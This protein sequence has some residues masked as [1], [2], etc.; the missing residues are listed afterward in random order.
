M[1]SYE[2]MKNNSDDDDDDHNSTQKAGLRVAVARGEKLA[3][4]TNSKAKA[5]A[6]DSS[7]SRE[8]GELSSSDDDDDDFHATASTSHLAGCDTA[9]ADQPDSA[10]ASSVDKVIQDA[11]RE[12]HDPAIKSASMVGLSSRASQRS[13]HLKSSEKNRG[14]FVPFVIS[15]SDDDSG[16]DS[17]D[18]RRNTL[19]TKDQTQGVDRSSRPPVSSLQRSPKL[20]QN[21]NKKARLVNRE[22]FPSRPFV[23][24]ATSWNCRQIPSSRNFSTVQKGVA[25]DHG[26]LQKSIVHVNTNKRQLQDLRQLIAIR[27]SQLKLKSTQQTK[28]SVGG[29]GSDGKFKNPGN[30]GNR[31]RKDSGFDLRG[32]LNKA[33]KKRLKTGKPQCS[34][35]D[36]DNNLHSLQPILTSGKSR[37]DNSGKE[38][39]DDH[40]HRSKKLSLGTSLSGVQKQSEARDSL[41]LENPLNTAIAGNCTVANN[42]QCARNPKQ[43]D[44]VI[45]LKQSGQIGKRATGDFPNRSLD[46]EEYARHDVQVSIQ[47]NVTSGTNLTER[48]DSDQAKSSDQVSKLKS[49]DKVQASSLHLADGNLQKASLSNPSLLNGLDKLNMMGNNMDL[50]SLLEYEELQDKEIEDAQEHRRRC[51]IEERNALM[52]YRKAQRALIEANARCSQLY[53]KR[54]LYSAQLRSLMM[55]NPNLVVSLRQHDQVE[56][57]LDSFNY[58]SDVNEHQIPAS[59]HQVH[60]G[61][62][63]NGIRGNN[64]N[65]PPAND[66]Y[67]NPSNMHV[68]GQNLVSDPCSKREG[69]P[70]EGHKQ[71]VSNGVCSPSGDLSQS[72]YQEG[73]IF[74]FNH[75]SAQENIESERT[76]EFNKDREKDIYEESERQPPFDS[77]QDCFLLEASL[78]SQLFEKLK[79]KKLPKKG[80]TQS[81]EDL[82][83]RNDENDDSRQMMETDTADV[84]LSEAENGKH[85]DYEDYSKEER[86]PELPVQINNQFDILH[87]EHASSS[88]DVC[89][90]SCISL[91]SQ[92]FK[93]SGTFLLPSMKCAFSALKFI[94]LCSV[95]ESN[96]AST[97][98]LISDV[99]EENEDNRVTCKSKPSTS[100]LDLPET[101]IN[102]FVGK[103]G[104]Y[105]CNLAIDPF[106]PLCMYELRGR[107]NNSECSWQHVRDYCCDN[108][109][110]DSTDYSVVQVR[111]QSPREQFDGAMVRRKSLNHVDLAAPTYVVSLDILRPDSQSF[112]ST[113]SQG[114]GQC[115]GKCFSAFLVLSS[116][117]PMVSQSNEPFLHGTQARIEVHCSWNRQTSYFNNRNGTLGQIDQCV[118]DAD[119]S[120]EIAILNF[121]QEA[122]K[123]KA[124]MQALKVLAQAIEDNPTSAVLW[125]VYLQIFYS[126]QKAIVKDDLFRYAVEYNKESYELWLLYINSRVQLDDRLAAYDIALLALSHHTST[127]DGDAM[128][129]SHCTLDIFL[130]MMNF[131]CMSGSAGMALEKIAGLFWSSKK[132]DNNL[133]LSLPDIVTCLTICDKFIFWIC[134]VYILL[135]K[136]LPDAVV[137]KFECRKECSAIEWP[138][139]SLRSDEKQQA[140]SLL[141]LAVDSLALYMDHESLE[142]ETTLRAAHLFALNHVR[143]V[144]VLEGLEC[145]RN[146][147]GKYIKLYPSCLELVLMSAWAEY[148]LGGS[149]FNGFEEALRNWPDEVPGIHCIWNQY[150]GCVFQ[151]GKFDF[152]KDLMDQWFHSVLEARYSDCGVLQAKDE[153]SDSSLISISVSDLHAWFFSCG[154]NDTV[155]GMLNLSLYKLL[156]NNQSEAQAALDLALKAATADNY[157]HCLRELVPFLLIDSIR[158]K[159]VVHLKGI[160]NILNVHL[161]DVRASLGAEPLSRDFIQKIKKPV[162]RQLVSKLLSPA[163]A[164]FSLMSLVLEVWYGL[165]L[166]PRVCDKVTDLVDFVEALMEILPSNYLLAFS[167]C[168]KLSSNATKCSASLSF[169]ASSLLVN[170]LFHAVPIA[171]EYAWVEAADVLHDLTD[172]KCIQE[173]FHKKAVS[174]YP[175][176]IKLWK[177]YLRLCETEG[178]VESV[179]KAAKEKGIELD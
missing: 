55:E 38:S 2:L 160:L 139:I 56:A 169:W 67:Q 6:N 17:D 97:G 168:K 32:E 119:Q 66:H 120:L 41:S 37:V 89:M 122:D 175:F 27:E 174:V 162:A 18:S 43:G 179:K 23:N 136:K 92:E 77:S 105:S 93:T 177:S 142:N 172:I 21:K 7:K 126:N 12:Q 14:P 76:S 113:S 149:N 62:D 129:A 24:G 63:I 61:S 86:C 59:S 130:Q 30:P 178:N 167:V 8:E 35:L 25:G 19:A 85:S 20:L 57:Q 49:D 171:P 58:V 40:D 96:N 144:S 29:S 115:W 28:N 101:S 94:E 91:G 133:Q 68:S 161:V 138:S 157:Q 13:D 150:V 65:V 155:F 100:N 110:H 154:Q 1:E 80:T 75:K 132:S 50:Q 173:S 34:Q 158:D 112:I 74:E 151:S 159:G 10:E 176:S 11:E 163:S 4:A 143:C 48:C 51:E 22:A 36:L 121:N 102:L 73:E 165:T 70:S 46:P 42:I 103:S 124:R 84:P 125:I 116:L 137:Q 82:V 166:L 72:S 140:A 109:K 148:D 147:L 117:C 104:Y 81:T 31:V 87:S 15:F 135:Y 69:S 44:P 95:L 108:M 52:A 111:R 114:Y 64:S 107:C 26:S 134:C 47:N 90:G 99:D 164:D 88:Q 79:T 153:K 106:W 127:S 71:P 5:A 123:Y 78:R 9:Q 170:A 3:P 146:L 54:E 53:S 141:E 131:L 83:E 156:Q 98:M 60:T 16:S 152:V 145:S 128:R 39:V 33:D 118:V 45:W